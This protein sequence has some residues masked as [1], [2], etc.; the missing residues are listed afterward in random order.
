MMVLVLPQDADATD[1]ISG[2]REKKMMKILRNALLWMVALPGGSFL[3]E[4]DNFLLT[5][6]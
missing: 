1:G 6:Q 5:N 2:E 4:T 3:L